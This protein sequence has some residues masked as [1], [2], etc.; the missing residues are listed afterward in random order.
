MDER[1]IEPDLKDLANKY[2]AYIF[3]TQASANNDDEELLDLLTP[4]IKERVTKAAYFKALLNCRFFKN[5]FSLQLLDEV[6]KYMASQIFTPQ[7]YIYKQ[8]KVSN[9]EEAIYFIERGDVKISSKNY[10]FN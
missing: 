7:E 6:S 3:L 4:E 9:S 10:E 5:N 1:D 2:V 8:G